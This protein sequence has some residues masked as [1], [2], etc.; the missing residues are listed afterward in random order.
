MSAVHA[1]DMHATGT[2]PRSETA[3]CKIHGNRQK[4]IVF[5]SIAADGRPCLERTTGLIRTFIRFFEELH[6]RFGR[7][8][9][10]MDNAPQ[11]TGARVRRYIKEN[12]SAN[13]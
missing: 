13:I 2:G 1:D 8:A 5:G 11:Y 10:I 6:R 9:V 7:I 3:G 12:L 4:V